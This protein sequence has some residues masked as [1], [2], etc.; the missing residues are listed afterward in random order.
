MKKIIC[1]AVWDDPRMIE[2]FCKLVVE[3]V[4]AGNRPL[5]TLN[6][7]GYKSLGRDSLLEP[8]NSIPKSNS[9]TVGIISR[10]YIISRNRF[11]PILT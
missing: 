5:G 3:E 4:N 7:R 9:R 8:E 6:R 1:K 2:F 11:G 10:F